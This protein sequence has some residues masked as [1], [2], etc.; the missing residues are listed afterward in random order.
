M[1]YE[2]LN[3][4]KAIARFHSVF[5][6]AGEP[7]IWRAPGRVN[8]IG[9]HTD[10]NLGLVLPMAIEFACFVFSA[11]SGDGWLRVHSEQFGE[12]AEWR[13]E[14]IPGLAARG[15]WSDRV[16]AVAWELLRAGIA[17]EGQNLLIDSEVPLGAG[18]SSSAALGVALTLALG[19]VAHDRVPQLA[20][21][22][23]VDFVGIPCGIMDQFVSAHGQSGTAILLDCRDLAWRP[24]PLPPGL[25]VVVAN[26]MV[27]HELGNSA[28]STRVVE[29]ETAA[30]RLGVHCLRDA[31]LEQLHRLDPT[32]RK[33]VRHVITENQRVEQFAAAAIAGDFDALGRLTIESHRSLRDDY[34]V[35][36][37]ELDFLVDTA[38]SVRGVLGARM[39]GGG[40]GGSTVNLLRPDAIGDLKDALLSRYHRYRGLVP[41]IYVCAASEGAAQISP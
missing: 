1:R 11:P 12:S 25:S 10:Y 6:S 14:D 24:I 31:Q 13:L 4:T 2:R 8:L 17:V 15:H 22:A 37:T 21:A 33:R 26:S 20:R 40:F 41:E 28:Y 5:A 27:K 29:C 35:S 7:S 18:L 34:E 9:E 38:L 39:T 19:D 23:E 32:L 3:L 36:C 30:N 16:A